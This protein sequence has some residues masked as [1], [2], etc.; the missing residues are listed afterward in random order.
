MRQRHTQHAARGRL[1]GILSAAIGAVMLFSPAWA[2]QEAPDDP[3]AQPPATERSEAEQ[4]GAA[5]PDAGAKTAEDVT[6][7]HQGEFVRAEG[8]S[9]T[10]THEG[11]EHSH[12]VQEDARITLN[13]RPAELSDLRA[14]DRI[15]VTTP[16][17]DWA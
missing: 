17:T 5:D 7:T 15:R 4:P 2:Q 14:G 6:M 10:M 11:R 1:L 3:F 8:D 9:F 13:G 12:R 16:K